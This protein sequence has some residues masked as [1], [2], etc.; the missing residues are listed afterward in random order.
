MEY[1]VLSNEIETTYRA[2]FEINISDFDK[3]YFYKGD[4]PHLALRQDFEASF[5]NGFQLKGYICLT[6]QS[7]NCKSLYVIMS[8]KG[9]MQDLIVKYDFS[10]NGVK[11]RGSAK[12]SEIEFSNVEDVSY[13]AKLDLKEIKEK[14]STCRGSI[15]I[16]FKPS[17]GV[18]RK[19][20]L[21]NL[22]SKDL[23]GS[24]SD[25]DS[26]EDFES[27]KNYTQSK[28]LQKIKK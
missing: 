11:I 6:D 2:K 8:E 10:I 25:L 14:F 27:L 9:L 16:E 26:F 12:G 4:I 19:Q 15:E 22:I 28:S 20:Q 1:K 24:D 5:K 18:M 23:Y 17:Y 13:G 21:I 7:L 3:Q